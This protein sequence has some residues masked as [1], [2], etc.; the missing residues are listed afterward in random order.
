[1]EWNLLSVSR[2]IQI[3]RRLDELLP[4]TRHVCVQ[5][6]QPMRLDERKSLV[7]SY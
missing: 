4:H 2:R 1:L 3:R 6:N 7:A 5:E